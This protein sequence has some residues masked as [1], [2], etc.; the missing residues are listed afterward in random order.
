MKEKVE[1]EEFEEVG[2]GPTIQ[3]LVGMIGRT[4]S[5]DTFKRKQNENRINMF[6]YVVVIHFK[7][8]LK[9]ILC[10]YT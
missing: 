8:E 4:G 7:R 3:G 10:C 1:Q 9:L 5:V 2:R 6:E